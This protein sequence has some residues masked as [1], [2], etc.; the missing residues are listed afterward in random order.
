MT[1]FFAL[2]LILTVAACGA[3]G[4]PE[5]VEGGIQVSAEA[6]IGVKGSF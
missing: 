4:P 2:M 3:D 5:P 6:K 1:R